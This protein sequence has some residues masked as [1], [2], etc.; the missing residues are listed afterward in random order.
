MFYRMTSIPGQT[1]GAPGLGPSS[2]VQYKNPPLTFSSIAEGEQGSQEQKV[3]NKA[4]NK[5]PM[6]E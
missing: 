3:N 2:S 1:A 4:R 5:E 6:D